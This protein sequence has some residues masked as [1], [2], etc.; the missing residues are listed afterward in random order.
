MYARFI[1]KTCQACSDGRLFSKNSLIWYETK[2]VGDA[3]NIKK[4]LI[5]N[6]PDI[7]SKI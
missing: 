4:I 6:A 1:R 7:F 3:V 5:G 2:Y